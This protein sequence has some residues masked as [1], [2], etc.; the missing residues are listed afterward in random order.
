[1]TLW[2]LNDGRG[3]RWSFC[4]GASTQLSEL[5]SVR[6]HSSSAARF[7]VVERMSDSMDNDCGRREICFKM[8]MTT[9]KLLQHRCNQITEGP[10]RH[11]SKPFHP[12][13]LVR[14]AMANSA[15]APDTH[16]ST[17]HLTSRFGP[18]VIECSGP[19]RDHHHPAPHTR[20]PSHTAQPNAIRT[21]SRRHQH[22]IQWR[23]A[24]VEA[25][26][27]TNYRLCYSAKLV[28]IVTYKNCF[29]RLSHARHIRPAS[30]RQTQA[31]NRAP[32]AT[33]FVDNSRWPH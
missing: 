18:L 11:H 17:T 21:P 15:I 27:S 2:P 19:P 13:T 24:A 32:S 25:L 16:T 20:Y 1:M 7:R 8:N 10:Q 26:L 22:R 28:L 14:L 33:V 4:P 12:I 9:K 23:Q 31:L 3:S 29:P 6:L 30:V 5:G